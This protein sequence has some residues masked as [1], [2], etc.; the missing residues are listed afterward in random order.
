MGTRLTGSTGVTTLPFG[1]RGPPVR[2]LSRRLT[3]VVEEFENF[4]S[5]TADH[6]A[7]LSESLECLR[8]EFE[9]VSGEQESLREAAESHARRLESDRP[10]KRTWQD[11]KSSRQLP[12]VNGERHVYSSPDHDMEIAVTARQTNPQN[13]ACSL[14]LHV[15]RVLVQTN[16]GVRTEGRR[17]YATINATIPANSEYDLRVGSN[18]KI[19]TWAELRE[20]E[21]SA[22]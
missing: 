6:I 8:S 18:L 3:Q 2:E 1:R 12:R 17:C 11:V 16:T 22:D 7:G 14:R 13:T 15:D 19:R 4:E 21:A 20:A 10:R 5:T 9:R